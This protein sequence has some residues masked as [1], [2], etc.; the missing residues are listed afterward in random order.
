MPLGWARGQ[1]IILYEN[2]KRIDR[3][4]VWIHELFFSF[5]I[6][7]LRMI[8]MVALLW[9]CSVCRVSVVVLCLLLA[10]LWDVG[11]AYPDCGYL[12]FY[13]QEE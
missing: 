7:S 2:R 4:G 1:N 5:E 8:G 9:L 11:R 12:L 13:F 6:I 3:D 10:V